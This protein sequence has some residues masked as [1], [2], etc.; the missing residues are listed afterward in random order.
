MSNENDPSSQKRLQVDE[1][2]GKHT[3][4]KLQNEKEKK[5]MKQKEIKE[6]L[7]EK[8]DE[9]E[10][11]KNIIE[12]FEGKKCSVAEAFTSVKQILGDFSGNLT[13]QT[14]QNSKEKVMQRMEDELRQC[15][16]FL[17]TTELSPAEVIENSTAVQGTLCTKYLDDWIEPRRKMVN[18]ERNVKFRTPTLTQRDNIVEHDSKSSSNEFD[19]AVEKSGCGLAVELKASKP[20]VG[21]AAK[22]DGEVQEENKSQNQRISNTSYFCKSTYS[23][24]PVKLWSASLSDLSLCN[25]IVQDLIQAEHLINI[26]EKGLAKE[27]AKNIFQ[28]YG[29][30]FYCGSIHY[31]GFFQVKTEFHS[32]EEST[33]SSIY[34]IVSKAHSAS[35]N[36]CLNVF[37][38]IEIEGSASGQKQYSIGNIDEKH[39]S[40]ELSKIHTSLTKLGGPVEI[41]SLDLWKK[42]L[43]QN[44]CSWVVVDGGKHIVTEDQLVQTS[45]VGLW[46]LVQ[47]EA[48]LFRNSI[49]LSNLLLDTW[50]DISG[51][52]VPEDILKIDKIHWHESKIGK[53]IANNACKELTSESCVDIFKTLSTIVQECGTDIG[54][55]SVW[56][57]ELRTNDRLHS[58][59]KKLLT[60]HFKEIDAIETSHQVS[61]LLDIANDIH[62][63][64]KAAVLNWLKEIEIPSEKLLRDEKINSID[65]FFVELNAIAFSKNIASNDKYALALLTGEVATAIEQLLKSFRTK[66]ALIEYMVLVSFVI[67]LEFDVKESKFRV[68][69]NSDKLSECI[70]EASKKQNDLIRFRRMQSSDT[71]LQA[72]LFQNIIQSIKSVTKDSEHLNMQ[73][74]GN[75]LRTMRFQETR[76]HLLKH[77]NFLIDRSIQTAIGQNDVNDILETLKEIAEGKMHTSRSHLSWTYFENITDDLQN[78]DKLNEQ[79]DVSVN[80]DNTVRKIDRIMED[81]LNTFGLKKYFPEKITVQ[82]ALAIH[83]QTSANTDETTIPWKILKNVISANSDFREKILKDYLNTLDT[84]QNSN[85]DLLDDLSSSDDDDKSQTETFHPSDVFLGLYQCCNP[86]LKRLIATKLV[87]CQF[88]IPILFTDYTN[89]DL[90]FSTW[91]INDIVLHGE[92]ETMITKARHSV[93]FIRV[94]KGSVPSKSKLINEFLRDFNEEHAT[95]IHKDCPLGM[96]R[97]TVSKGMIEMAWLIPDQDSSTS[98]PHSNEKSNEGN[99]RAPLNIFNLRGDA[100]EFDRQLHILLLLSNLIVILISY[101]DLHEDKFRHVLQKV[102]KSYT[103]V[104]VLTNMSGGREDKSFLKNYIKDMKIDKSKTSVISTMDKKK[105]VSIEANRLSSSDLKEILTNN[106]VKLLLQNVVGIQIQKV[107]LNLPEGIRSDESKKCVIGRRLAESLLKACKVDGSPESRKDTILP[108]QG[109]SLWQEISKREKDLKRTKLNVVDKEETILKNIRQ[110]RRKQTDICNT[111]PNAFSLFVKTLLKYTKDEE[112]IQYFIIWFKQ[113]LN[114]QSRVLLKDLLQRFLTAFKN[115]ESTKDSKDNGSKSKD[116]LDKAEQSLAEASFGVEHFFREVGQIYEAFMHTSEDLKCKITYQTKAVLKQLPFVVAKLLLLGHPFEIMDGDA[117][118]V[119]QQWVAAVLREVQNIVG[120]KTKIVTV[121]V[122][123][124]Q[125]SGKST[126]LN[127]MFG[128]EFSVSAGRCTR[129]I[130]IQLV[131]VKNFGKI[132]A[133]YLLVLDT[134]GLRAPESAGEKIHHDNEIATLVVGLADVVLLNL[135]GESIS[136]MANILEIVITGLLRLQQVN[137]N[138]TLRQSCIFIHQNVS[139]DA[140]LQLLQGNRNIV[141]NLDTM[142]KDVAIQEKITN[143]KHFA[144]VIKFNPTEDIKY[145]PELFHGSPGMGPVNQKYSLEVTGVQKCI[146]REKA[147]VIQ[148]VT[149]ENYLLHLQSLWQGIQAEDFIFSFRNILEIKSYSILESEYQRLIWELEELKLEWMNNNIKPRLHSCKDVVS[150]DKCARTLIEE[151]REKMEDKYEESD[152]LLKEFVKQS[153]LQEHME[154]YIAEKCYNMKSKKIQFEQDTVQSI[155][156]E[157]EKCTSKLSREDILT[158][159]E[160]Q[161]TTTARELAR[162][163]SGKK[164]TR[165]EMNNKFEKLWTQFLNELASELPQNTL[166]EKA[167]IMKCEIETAL[168]ELY[169]KYRHLLR[170]GLK[171]CAIDKGVYRRCLMDGLHFLKIDSDHICISLSDKVKNIYYKHNFNAQ[172]LNVLGEMFIDID[173]DFANL[174]AKETEYNQSQFSAIMK[175]VVTKFTLTNRSS[176]DYCFTLTPKLEITIALLVARH[177]FHMFKNMNKNYEKKYGLQAR[178]EAKRPR[179]HQLFLDTCEK[180]AEEI[181]ATKVLC[182]ELK[183]S[184]EEKLRR[185]LSLKMHR[186]IVQKFNCQKHHLMKSIMEDLAAI[187]K[188]EFFIKY[189]RNPET[190]VEGWIKM[191]TDNEIFHKNN[192]GRSSFTS[193]LEITIIGIIDKIKSSSKLTTEQSHTNMC[194]WIQCF[195]HHIKSS[196][197]ALILNNTSLQLLSDHDIKNFDGFLLSIFKKLSELET[198]LIKIWK[199]KKAC[200]FTWSDESP[201]DLTYKFLWGCSSKCPWCHEPCQ[202]SDTQH[203]SQ[204]DCHNCIQH[205][206]KGVS[207][208]HSSETG[209]LSIDSC[210][211][212]VQ[213]TLTLQCGNWCNCPNSECTLYHQYRE[214]KTYMKEWDVAPLADTS[215]SKYWNWF[216]KSYSK[217]LVEY[218]GHEM[219]TIPPSWE[220]LTKEDAIRS[221]SKVYEITLN[222]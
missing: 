34:E 44:N 54:Q 120:P 11:M 115:H 21:G 151:C 172:A 93:A 41:N 85:E 185:E 164:P 184:I 67:L 111:A 157:K 55:H 118:N 19:K 133:D 30:H 204:Q 194:D 66:N 88:A 20:I 3:E 103:S 97:R 170:K 95:F 187:G 80:T 190:Y 32:E 37:G 147:H 162:V 10:K 131:P 63:P 178:L 148:P 174:L 154:H 84:A 221:L 105:D 123:G 90:V 203:G 39:K 137:K 220:S 108:I 86:F 186:E 12:K 71:V 208:I 92:T 176:S 199:G 98:Q 171:E 4:A 79:D 28:T 69:L 135:K 177:S 72:L 222:V 35:V 74:K 201:Y 47:R 219:P 168:N 179:V 198:E 156:H 215:H 100:M 206:P 139:K 78:T 195:Q 145:I 214:Y 9:I 13:L 175:R 218:Y 58:L 210:N 130:Y 42:G 205:R 192:S 213:S 141:K 197:L 70:K 117:A 87:F 116:E 200:D 183:I 107:T 106:I 48:S 136:D 33:R 155:K 31:G 114:N 50:H 8:Q 109:K 159:K 40:V 99:I 89:N 27:K 166:A 167:E 181:I 36:A 75:L 142:T 2:N 132:Q 104:I 188:F 140:Q 161:I 43:V 49:A 101:D 189:I 51:L 76:K 153:E 18:I 207:G 73:N 150:I 110:L 64:E 125:S 209:I 211:F 91:P 15:V 143:I 169:T 7:K 81:I 24:V 60:V 163:F 83:D 46:N 202:K 216:M 96:T 17:Q 127:T 160:K 121:S 138:L 134:E 52:N 196:N 165:D 25:D 113:M 193:W 1:S 212:A 22:Y 146:L 144:D 57:E 182:D 68:Q 38:I 122:L 102:H 126:L 53:F 62:F 152:K 65:T 26:Q 29:S 112:I 14:D 124:I 82:M 128:L 173:Q 217:Q 158:L 61:K 5:M 56:I 180:Q 149:F 6:K 129:G 16:D 119:P 77:F 59:F 191:I 45:F 23:V 94:G